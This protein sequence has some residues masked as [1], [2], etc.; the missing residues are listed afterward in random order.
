MDHLRV[1]RAAALLPV[2]AIPCAALAV[3]LAAI[4]ACISLGFKV[5]EAAV[6]ALLALKDCSVALIGVIRRR[7]SS[8]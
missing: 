1:A 8:N 7:G 5:L 4:V 6:P 2:V 3:V